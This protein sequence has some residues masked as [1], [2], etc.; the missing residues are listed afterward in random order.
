MS[1]AIAS[2]EEPS[3]RRSSLVI[4]LLVR[5]AGPVIDLYYT[6]AHRLLP[7]TLGDGTDNVGKSIDGPLLLSEDVTEGLGKGEDEGEVVGFG[8][9]G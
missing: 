9:T 2:G 7:E 3:R 8:F 5:R 6:A 1:A 4:L